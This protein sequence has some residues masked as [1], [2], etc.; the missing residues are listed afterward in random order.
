MCTRCK[1]LIKAIDAYI[2][3][4][5]NELSDALGEA[6]FVQPKSTVKKISALEDK[7]TSALEKETKYFKG[8]AKEAVDLKAFAKGFPDLIEDDDADKQ[9]SE[10]FLK[11]FKEN[12]PG[13]AAGYIKQVDPKLTVKTITA[14]TLTWVENWSKKLGRLM[15]LDS[16]KEIEALLSDT[17]KEGKGIADFVRLLGDKDIRSERYR[18]RAVALTET[19]R[20]HSVA[21]QEAL[22][23]N[24]AVESKEWVHTGNYRNSPRENH[25]AM[26]G[27]I[28]PKD[29][30]FTLEGADGSTYYPMYP[31]DPTLPPGESVNCHCIH[32]GIVNEDIL[33]LSLAERKRLQ[34]EAIDAD[35]EAWE[36]ELDAKNKT[37]AG[38]EEAQL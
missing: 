16:H 6:G 1:A 12:I 23:Q 4:A 21:Q 32:R 35:D 31:R 13:L 2:A 22:T 27:V 29:E 11:D 10:L 20:A 36:E 34:Q 28:V 19:L 26:N 30:P 3:K 25:A 38:I 17:L 5:D 9:L 33:G 7:L 24:P 18:A 8:K 14:R 15:K 37:K